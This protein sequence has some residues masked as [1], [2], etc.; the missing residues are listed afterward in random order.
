MPAPSRALL[1]GLA[2]QPRYAIQSATY[3]GVSVANRGDSPFTPGPGKVWSINLRIY[4]MQL[5][6]RQPLLGGAIQKIVVTSPAGFRQTLEPT[7]DGKVTLTSLP[8]GLYT[9]TTLSDGV[10][11]T[12][13]VQVT[14][15]QAV[16]LSAFTPLELAAVSALALAAI[17]GVLGAALV[18]QMWPRRGAS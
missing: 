13:V 10:A 15:N 14:R 16:Q 4:S 6:V 8:R 1:L 7:R 18:F 2:Q 9:V 11:P 5:Q 12:L 17:T 3:D